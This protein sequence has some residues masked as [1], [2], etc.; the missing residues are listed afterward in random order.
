[1]NESMS[2]DIIEVCIYL[3]FAFAVTAVT[4]TFLAFV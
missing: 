3:G 2:K 1:M 4:L